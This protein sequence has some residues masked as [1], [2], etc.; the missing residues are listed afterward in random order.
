MPND[1]TDYTFVL[2]PLQSGYCK[3]PKF[4]VKFNNYNFKTSRLQNGLLIQQV[5]ELE[6]S[7]IISV[8]KSLSGEE[9]ESVELAKIEYVVQSMLPTQIFIMP[10][11][12]SIATS[13]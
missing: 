10:Q 6:K 5:T 3:L 7:E 9:S 1:S 8:D 11:T 12:T 4:R 13:S 2:Y